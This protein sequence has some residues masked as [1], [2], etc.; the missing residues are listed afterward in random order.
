MC[1]VSRFVDD[2]L[3]TCPIP[4]NKK[5][6]ENG[7]Q[8]PVDCGS[9]RYSP[10]PLQ[11]AHQGLHEAIISGSA[12]PAIRAMAAAAHRQPAPPPAVALQR[13][14]PTGRCARCPEPTG[15]S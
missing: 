10:P 7:H 8:D 4:S 5:R 12:S 13:P 3:Q 9:L 6:K 2:T 15:R 1:V 11:Q 14:A